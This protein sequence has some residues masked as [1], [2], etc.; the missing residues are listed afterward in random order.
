MALYRPTIFGAVSSVIFFVRALI[1]WRNGEWLDVLTWALLGVAFALTFVPKTTFGKRT[2]LVAGG[3][4]TV[5]TIMFLLDA[6]E[7]LG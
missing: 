3:T 4:L 5:G 2:Q 6:A 7:R 1:E